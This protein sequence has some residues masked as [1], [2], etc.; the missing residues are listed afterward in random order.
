VNAQVSM[1]HVIWSKQVGVPSQDAMSA[2]VAEPVQVTIP[3]IVG[4][5]QAG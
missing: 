5:S 1:L 3:C 4:V 2:Q